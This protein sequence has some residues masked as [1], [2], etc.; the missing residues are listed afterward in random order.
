MICKI[1]LRILPR[2]YGFMNL[3]KI[4]KTA[5]NYEHYL[6]F[7][8]LFFQLQ[9][10]LSKYIPTYNIQVNFNQDDVKCMQLANGI[11]YKVNCSLGE[12][13]ALKL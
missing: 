13:R 9:V 4:L 10:R 2:L 8:F 11:C 7:V 6:I 3:K 12:K 1:M 5:S